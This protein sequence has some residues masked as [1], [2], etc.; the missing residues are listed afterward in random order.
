MRGFAKSLYHHMVVICA[1]HGCGL[2][3]P[4]E[5]RGAC[6]RLSTIQRDVGGYLSRPFQ[7]NT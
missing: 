2:V 7:E 4:F 1:L 3:L 6:D 5:K